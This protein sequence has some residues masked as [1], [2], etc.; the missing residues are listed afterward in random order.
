MYSM[1]KFIGEEFFHVLPSPS[2]TRLICPCLHLDPRLPGKLPVYLQCFARFSMSKAMSSANILNLWFRFPPQVPL[3]QTVMEHRVK[4]LQCLGGLLLNGG[5]VNTPEC[6]I[7]ISSPVSALPPAV[8]G[9]WWICVLDLRV[10]VPRRWSVYSRH[11]SC[12]LLLW[13]LQVAF[14]PL[15]SCLTLSP[16]ILSGFCLGV[17]PSYPRWASACLQTLG[18]L[19][20]MWLQ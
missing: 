8:G 20:R 18:L 9:S 1:D 15:S 4:A 12:N 2:G 16:T 7:G 19:W 17:R 11:V 5:R 10:S 14:R 13:P 3:Q 6:R